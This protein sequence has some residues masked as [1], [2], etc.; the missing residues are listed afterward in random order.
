MEKFNFEKNLRNIRNSKGISQDAMAFKLGISQ[1]TYSRIE[2]GEITPSYEL[3][4]KMAI[5]FDVLPEALTGP[6]QPSVNKENPTSAI[7]YLSKPIV[8]III[9]AASLFL[10]ITI[11]SIFYTIADHFKFSESVSFT[12]RMSA[13]FALS[14]YIIHLVKKW[15]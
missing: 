2:R 1:T 12:M 10:I 3:T 14:F 7:P 9:V 5:E 13:V 6:I 11:H 15:F 8:M 4:C